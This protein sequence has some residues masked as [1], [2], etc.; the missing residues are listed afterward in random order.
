MAMS[1]RISDDEFLTIQKMVG[2]SDG[3]YDSVEEWLSSAIIEKFLKE[4]GS[5]L[6]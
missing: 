4:N 3:K 1:I 5:A 2:K 6:L